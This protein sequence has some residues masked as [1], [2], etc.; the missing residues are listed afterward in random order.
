[1]SKAINESVASAYPET[2]Y[3]VAPVSQWDT[4][5]K[6]RCPEVLDSYW[7]EVREVWA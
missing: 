6:R 3:R 4:H 1:M 5:P 2:R 7:V